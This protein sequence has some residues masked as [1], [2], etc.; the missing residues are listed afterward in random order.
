V[1]AAGATL[2]ATSTWRTAAPESRHEAGRQGR[3]MLIALGVTVTFQIGY[4]LKVDTLSVWPRYFALHYF[5]LLW[6]VALAFR[7]MLDTAR[8]PALP[9]TTRRRWRLAASAAFAVMLVS[10]FLQVRSYRHN[11]YLDTGLSPDSNWRVISGGLARLT[12]PG[13][14]I[15][16]QD[17][18]QAW[19]LTFT[20]PT[21]LP[22][23]YPSNLNAESLAKARR[24]VYLEYEGNM[25]ARAGIA[26]SLNALGFGPARA[27]PLPAG[28]T[29]AAVPYWHVVIFPRR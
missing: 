3:L 19:T 8:S 11:P 21:S 15:L 5:F 14:T 17:F 4:F 25:P 6:L 13:D 26:E 20:R 29:A 28:D 10:A 23:L 7:A 18:L 16:M 22:V 2:Y 12:Q 24:L 1:L 27:E 9:A